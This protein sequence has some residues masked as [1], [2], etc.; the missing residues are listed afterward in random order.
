IGRA[1]MAHPRL[2]LLDEPSMGLAP[3]LVGEIFEIVSRLNREEGV[4]VLLAA[5]N[6][7][8]APK[9]SQYR[10]GMA[11][12][13]SVLDGGAPSLSDYANKTRTTS[14]SGCWA[15]GNARATAT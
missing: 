15:S 2:M 12:R 7:T 5:Q 3:L 10:Y 14:I 1:L 11:S 13:R 6:A 4:A 8:M 9:V